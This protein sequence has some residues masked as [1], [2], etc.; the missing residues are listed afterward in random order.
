[1]SYIYTRW[2]SFEPR[3]LKN[4]GEVAGISYHLKQSLF[5]EGFVSAFSGIVGH[6]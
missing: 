4:Y 3:T 1:M 2:V 5:P 6:G